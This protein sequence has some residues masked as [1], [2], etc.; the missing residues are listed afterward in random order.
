MYVFSSYYIYAA[1]SGKRLKIAKAV[2]TFAK[3]K[4]QCIGSNGVRMNAV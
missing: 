3:S 1:K 2:P 4:V